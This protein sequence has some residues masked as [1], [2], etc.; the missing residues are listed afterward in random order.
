MTHKEI[1]NWSVC[2]KNSESRNLGICGFH[3]LVFSLCIHIW[4]LV[5][6]FIYPFCK[7]A[8]LRPDQ[9]KHCYFKAFSTRLKTVIQLG[10]KPL[11]SCPLTNWVPDILAGSKWLIMVTFCLNWTQCQ[12]IKQEIQIILLQEGPVG[13]QGGLVLNVNLLFVFSVK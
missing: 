9:T 11:S 10:A 4:F 6:H 5:I 1:L 3:M 12:P 2:L 13:C 7:A 8:L